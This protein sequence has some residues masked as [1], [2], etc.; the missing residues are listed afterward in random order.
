MK[1]M[2]LEFKV[3]VF[4]IVSLAILGIL[5]VKAGDFYMKPGYT[6]RLLFN[7]V[8]GVD[9]GSPVRLA[10]VNV[11][12]VKEIHIIRN[13][14]GQTQVECLAWISKDAKIEEDSR[15]RINSLGLLGEKYIEILP[16]TSGTT[17]LSNNGLLMGKPPAN[18]EEIVD[19]GTR[20]INKIEFTVENI[21]D[22]VADPAFKA[23]VKNTFTNADK[24]TKDLSEMTSDLKEAVA[25]AKVVLGRLR[26]GEGSVGRLLKDDKIAKDLEAF[27]ADI[28]AHPWKLLK[29]N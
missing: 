24:L 8:S 10:G 25:S 6:V 16:G 9:T 2:G 20:L 28:K 7:Y 22:V 11:G 4:V 18:M 13:E 3:G 14:K 29:R 23:S 15:V 21:N 12:E 27:V 1:K 5:V 26:D 17:T 19:S